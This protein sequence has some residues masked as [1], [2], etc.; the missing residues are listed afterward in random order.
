MQPSKQT[1]SYQ[2]VNIENSQKENGPH[3]YN[4]IIKSPKKKS[5]SRRLKASSQ[6]PI[7]QESQAVD[8][9]VSN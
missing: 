6:S 8:R 2:I 5:S 3:K 9:N 4:L 1:T 7:K